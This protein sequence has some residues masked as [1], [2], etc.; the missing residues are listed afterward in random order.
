M[1]KLARSRTAS[2]DVVFFD[3]DVL[4]AAGLQCKK[5]EYVVV[6]A[7]VKKYTDARGVDK[8]Q[9]LVSLPG[10]VLA[11]SQQLEEMLNDGPDESDPR[12][13]KPSESDED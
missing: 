9:L 4:I 8:L 1:V 6:K 10:Q 12:N 13:S 11:P 3:K 7:T 2:L 5:G